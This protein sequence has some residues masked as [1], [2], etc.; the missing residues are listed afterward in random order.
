MIHQTPGDRDDLKGRSWFIKPTRRKRLIGEFQRLDPCDILMINT[1]LVH[2]D[3][4]IIDMIKLEWKSMEWWY[5][6]ASESCNSSLSL[7]PAIHFKHHSLCSQAG[8]S[9]KITSPGCKPKYWLACH[10]IFTGSSHQKKSMMDLPGGKVTFPLVQHPASILTGENQKNG[11]AH[12]LVTWRWESTQEYPTIIKA[13]GE[14]GFN[15]CWHRVNT[16]K[17]HIGSSPTKNLVGRD[18]S[19]TIIWSEDEHLIPAILAWTARYQEF[20]THICIYI[21]IY[22]YIYTYIYIYVYIHIHIYI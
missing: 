10:R 19:E 17:N 21:Y 22:T 12:W 1:T 15:L 8:W 2:Y 9:K 3:P 13:V 6:T 14:C 20:E 5:H 4:G 11:S 18:T 7:G 16:I